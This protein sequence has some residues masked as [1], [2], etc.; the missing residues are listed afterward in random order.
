MARTPFEIQKAVVFALFVRELKTRFG[1]YRLGYVWALLQPIA[2]VMVLS[3][4]GVLW[5]EVI[6]LGYL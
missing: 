4:Y 6:F 2:H 3:V 1:K 5:G